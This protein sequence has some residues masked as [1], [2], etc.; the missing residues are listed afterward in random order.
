M[1]WVLILFVGVGMAGDGES[2]A[3]TSVPGFASEAACE[4]AGKAATS[5]FGSGTKRAQYVC[6]NQGAKQS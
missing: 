2:N 4:A 5:K 3:L 6:A 1:T